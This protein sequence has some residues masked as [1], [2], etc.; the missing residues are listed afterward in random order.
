MNPSANCEI[1]AGIDECFAQRTD[2]TCYEFE[3]VWNEPLQCFDVTIT[4]EGDWI[5]ERGDPLRVPQ[6]AVEALGS[7]REV[8]RQIA[9]LALAKGEAHSNTKRPRRGRSVPSPSA[10]SVRI[11]PGHP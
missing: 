10:G 8:G 3:L 6:D 9:A 1:L 4:R 2:R 7:L 5:T 11:G